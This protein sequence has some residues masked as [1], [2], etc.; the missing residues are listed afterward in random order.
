MDTSPNDDLD[1]LEE[2]LL[3]ADH[4]AYTMSLSDLDGFLT[5]IAIS[6]QKIPSEE[7]LAEIWGGVMPPLV[8]QA[9]NGWVI[10]AIMSHYKTIQQRL[11]DEPSVCSPML[12][13]D[14][15]GELLPE[16]WAKGFMLGVDLRR[17]AWEPLFNSTDF[18]ALMVIAAFALADDP[19][20]VDD[21]PELFEDDPEFLDDDSKLEEL[22]RTSRENFALA[23]K[24]LHCFWQTAKKQPTA[25]RRPSFLTGKVGRNALCP[26]DSGKKYK[27]CCGTG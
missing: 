12:E 4:P 10:G 22:R 19:E 5:A 15:D 8:V 7:W 6:P 26:C 16:S 27:R 23:V 21:D 9:E 20:L 14:D 2:Y 13:F 18:V 17:K 24:S 11:A 1:R 3:S 25:M